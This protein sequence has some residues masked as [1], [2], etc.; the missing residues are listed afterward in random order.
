MFYRK[1]TFA[2]L[3]ML[4]LTCLILLAVFGQTGVE[5]R[6]QCQTP[7][8]SYRVCP[9]ALGTVEMPCTRMEV[10][11]QVGCFCSRRYEGFLDLYPCERR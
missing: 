10:N 1:I 8:C 11:G 5:R 3:R 6:A 7:D 2:R 9:N 4:V